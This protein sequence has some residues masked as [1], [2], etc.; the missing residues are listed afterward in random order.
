MRGVEELRRAEGGWEEERIC[1]ERR[2]KEQRSW[3][4]QGCEPAIFASRNVIGS[5]RVTVRADISSPR[6]IPSVPSRTLSHPVTHLATVAI[7]RS[8]L[9][10][11]HHDI[12]HNVS[13]SLS[14]LS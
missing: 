6:G 13:L 2:C 8:S 5:R 1:C 7:A 9:S 3:K 4:T 12:I 14:I 10:I 11:I